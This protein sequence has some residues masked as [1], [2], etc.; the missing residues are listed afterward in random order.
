M[1]DGPT[2]KDELDRLNKKA[3]EQTERDMAECL[4]SL[5]WAHWKRRSCLS[6]QD[7]FGVM[8]PVIAADG[9]ILLALEVRAGSNVLDIW[10]LTVDERPSCSLFVEASVACAHQNFN[11]S[12]IPTAMM[13]ILT[14][15]TAGHRL[16][17]KSRRGGPGVPGYQARGRRISKA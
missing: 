8:A 1:L 13:A 3:E 9:K 2:T 16:R 4:I 12:S 14:R 5:P 11:E 17:Y 7:H 10:R 15:Y 6:C